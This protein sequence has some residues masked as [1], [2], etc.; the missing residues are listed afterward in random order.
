[1]SK[2]FESVLNKQIVNYFEVNNL[3]SNS[4]FGYRSG[5]G[6]VKAA[7]SFVKECLTKLDSKDSVS[8]KLYDMSKAFDTVS[9]S[10]LLDKFR[11]YGFNEQAVTLLK[12]YLSGRFQ[13]VIYGGDESDFSLVSH[14]VPQGS[15]LGPILFIVYINDLPI[16]ISSP[17]VHSYLFADD[18]SVCFNSSSRNE[19]DIAVQST[20][21]IVKDWCSANLLCI[22][23]DK[24]QELDFSYS[25]NK[26]VHP[27]NVNFLGFILDH[28][29]NWEEHVRKIESKVWKGVYLIRKLRLCVSLRVLKMVYYAQIHCHLS[30]G[31]LLWGHRPSCS[32]LLGLQKKCVRLMCGLS[33][34]A[35][36]KLIFVQLGIMTVPA[37]F[38]YQ[39]LL[40]MKEN[41]HLYDSLG[42]MHNYTTRNKDSVSYFRCNYTKTQRSFYYMSIKFHNALP[43]SVKQLPINK[44][45]KWLSNVLTN[46]CL[47]KIEEFFDIDFKK[48]LNL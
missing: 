1:M 4:Q 47:Y 22:N 11:F 30:Y 26:D 17:I 10:N 21:A 39:C 3:F 13:K 40:Y 48:Y 43:L 31:T 9:H 32:R 16:N 8:V 36:C 45:K 33:E 41:C 35:H 24:I 42:C 38:I 5:L 14:G 19:F 2:V 7:V 18:L 20:S 37:I 27:S 44:F 6:T 23:N 12:S 15:I 34:L 28:N 46:N 29:L 25:H